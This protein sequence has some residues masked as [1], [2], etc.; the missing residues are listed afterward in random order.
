MVDGSAGGQF[1]QSFFYVLEKEANINYKFYWNEQK[2]F[3][4]KMIFYYLFCFKTTTSMKKFLV[5]KK[6]GFYFV[7]PTFYSQ[8]TYYYVPILSTFYCRSN[9][10][11]H[12]YCPN[13]GLKC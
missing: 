3:L 7:L 1:A 11:Y 9:S 13:S 10:F 6:G 8:P 12:M 5:P 2:I 4:I